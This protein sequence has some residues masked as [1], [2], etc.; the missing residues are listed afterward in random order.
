MI[1]RKTRARLSVRSVA[2]VKWAGYSP[3][4]MRTTIFG[5]L[6]A[7]LV[8]A[9]GL[10]VAFSGGEAEAPPAAAPSAWNTVPVTGEVDNEMSEYEARQRAA[11]TRQA[12]GFTQAWLGPENG[13]WRRIRPFLAPTL[14]RPLTRAVP[15]ATLEKI[16]ITGAN[17]FETVAVATLSDGSHLNLALG[18]D[19]DTWLVTRLSVAP[20]DDL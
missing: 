7:L 17:P 9:G 10:S 16:E 18:Y 1:F 14:A 12:T 3:A 11:A 20:A 15:D 19:G 2:A 8:V 6:I 4:R 13:W 5:S